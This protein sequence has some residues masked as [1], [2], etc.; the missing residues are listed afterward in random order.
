MR[1]SMSDSDQREWYVKIP[2]TAPGAGVLISGGKAWMLKKG[3]DNA[4]ASAAVNFFD[5]GGRYGGGEYSLSFTRKE[6]WKKFR[7]R[8]MISDAEV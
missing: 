2:A 3:S 1:I 5:G 8:D 6:Q 4:S 7:L